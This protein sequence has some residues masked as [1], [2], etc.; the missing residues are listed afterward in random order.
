VSPRPQFIGSPHGDFV[1][2]THVAENLD[3]LSVDLVRAFTH[4]GLPFRMRTTNVASVVR[5][6]PTPASAART[7]SSEA[8]TAG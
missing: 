1:S 5:A 8:H 7:L 4:S 2:L 3:E 6:T